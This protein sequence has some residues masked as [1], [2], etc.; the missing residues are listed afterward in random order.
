MAECYKCYY[1]SRL[2]LTCDFY[3]IHGYR[4]S[5]PAAECIDFKPRVSGDLDPHI[6][7]M[8]RLYYKGLSDRG[9]ARNLGIS[10]YKVYTWRTCYGL[11][12]NGEAQ[13]GRPRKEPK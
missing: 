10:R 8:E 6:L 4:K 3:L 7:D 11:P 12:A 5:K 9:I 2:T 1:R 13:R